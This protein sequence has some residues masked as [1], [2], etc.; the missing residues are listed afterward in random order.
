MS[1]TSLGKKLRYTVGYLISTD[2]L[3][4]IYALQKFFNCSTFLYSENEKAA[5]QRLT[6]VVS[7]TGNVGQQF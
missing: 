6:E 5:M 4:E 2:V 7:K 3:L 1:Y